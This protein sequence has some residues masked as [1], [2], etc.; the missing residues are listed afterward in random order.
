MNIIDSIDY[1]II[2]HEIA[3]NSVKLWFANTFGIHTLDF[4]LHEIVY[5]VV[6]HGSNYTWDN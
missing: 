6:E 4:K 2:C 3:Q 1:T 5:V